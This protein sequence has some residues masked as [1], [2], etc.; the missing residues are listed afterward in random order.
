M[1]LQEHRW[2]LG[3]E[4]QGQHALPS[5]DCD[6]CGTEEE[7][8]E[9]EIVLIVLEFAKSSC[10]EE[11]MLENAQYAGSAEYSQI[12][13]CTRRVLSIRLHVASASIA[14]ALA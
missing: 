3:V 13:Y 8:F 7:H 12:N 9:Q 10:G 1:A 14:V 4:Y 11:L 2:L 6:C 5:F